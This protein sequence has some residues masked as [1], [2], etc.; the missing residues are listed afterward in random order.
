MVGISECSARLH[1]VVGNQQSFD[2][3]LQEGVQGERW[4][5]GHFKI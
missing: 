5:I 2:I 1:T 4:L 3:V